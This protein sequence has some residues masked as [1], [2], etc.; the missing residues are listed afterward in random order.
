MVAPDYT[1]DVSDCVNV[2]IMLGAT[3]ECTVVNT[4]IPPPVETSFTV[5]KETS[6]VSPTRSLFRSRQSLRCRAVHSSTSGSLRTVS[7]GCVG[8][9]LPCALR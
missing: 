3:T 6:V 4:Y 1:S 7:G 9:G 5:R 8:R 2:F